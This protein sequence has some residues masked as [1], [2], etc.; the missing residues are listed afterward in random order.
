MYFDPGFGSMLIQALLATVAACGSFFFIFRG[1]VKSLFNKK[2]ATVE[3]DCKQ[4]DKKDENC[5][6]I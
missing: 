6:I 5:S 4:E 2:N 1:K 3:N